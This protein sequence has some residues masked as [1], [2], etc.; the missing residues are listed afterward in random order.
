MLV[1]VGL[2]PMQAVRAMTIWG[3][4]VMT[5]RRQVP[6]MPPVGVIGPGAFADIVV[7]GGLGLCIVGRVTQTNEPAAFHGALDLSRVV[8][9]VERVG[10]RSG[11]SP[12]RRSRKSTGSRR[13]PLPREVRH[14]K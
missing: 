6:T 7:L 8:D 9:V 10:C 11:R 1:E 13:T 2:T 14:L 12:R 3:A 5:A 4:E